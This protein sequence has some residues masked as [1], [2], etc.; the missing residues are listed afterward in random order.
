MVPP[1][2]QDPAVWAM[3]VVGVG[4]VLSATKTLGWI[5]DLFPSP[6]FCETPGFRLC[7]AAF[8]LVCVVFATLMLVLN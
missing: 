3:L 5:D 8:G 7:A 1:S 2:Y 4:I 6:A